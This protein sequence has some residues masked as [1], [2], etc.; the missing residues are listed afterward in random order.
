MSCRQSEHL[1]KD[2]SLPYALDPI[3]AAALARMGKGSRGRRG[4]GTQI[5]G[6]TASGGGGRKHARGGFDRLN[7]RRGGKGGSGAISFLKGAI[8]FLNRKWKR[9]IV[10]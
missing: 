5:A 10:L 3:V 7:A 2:G 8:S 4:D 9:S 1:A 6:D